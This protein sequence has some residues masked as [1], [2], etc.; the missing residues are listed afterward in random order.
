[1][2]DASCSPGSH[3]HSDRPNWRAAET[4]EDYL[5]NCDED[6]E[7]YSDRRMAKLFGISRAKLW[8]WRL[9]AEIPDELFDRL[10]AEGDHKTSTKE[11]AAV[12]LALSGRGPA[13]D[14]ERCPHCGKVVRLRRLWRAR[15]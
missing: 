9:M 13:S 12:G 11:L 2:T 10:L 7:V 1:M 5:H 15:T 4:A 8:R 14:V 6:L 3:P